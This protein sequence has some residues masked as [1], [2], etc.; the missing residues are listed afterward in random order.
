MA[1]QR[2]PIPHGKMREACEQINR[3]LLDWV[4]REGIEHGTYTS[5]AE[6]VGGLHCELVKLTALVNAG[7]PTND[8]GRRM[9]RNQL[10]MIAFTAIVGM[11]SCDLNDLEGR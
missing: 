8:K 1:D 9:T 5:D 2:H 3:L 11:I 4:S 10:E 6:I 7:A